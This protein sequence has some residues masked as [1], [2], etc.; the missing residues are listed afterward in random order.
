MPLN[1]DPRFAGISLIVI[2]ILL[3][4]L[5][6]SFT[7]EIGKSMRADCTGCT[8]P[9]ELCPHA[10]NLPWQ[11]YLGFTLS[12]LLIVFGSYILLSGRGEKKAKARRD[13]HAESV[14]KTLDTDDRKLYSIIKE[15]DGV[16]FQSELVEKTG[17]PK[18]KVT[19]ILD[20]LEGRGLLERRRRGMSNIIVLKH[21]VPGR[22]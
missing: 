6:W 16:M 19:R 9:G 13:R 18:V 5:I 20:R 3:S 14:L 22:G 11:S 17:F 4:L 2:G 15:S 7:D 8:A 10:M 1:T 12:G 21:E